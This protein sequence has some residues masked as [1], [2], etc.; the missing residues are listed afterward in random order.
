[1]AAE[2][3]RHPYLLSVEDVAKTLGTDLDRGLSSAQ[4]AE[5][6]Q[7]YPQNILDVG[8]AIPW[9]KI[10]IKQLLNAMIL[11]STLWL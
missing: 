3:E 10:F 2:F 4:V 6:Q 5:L 1:M 11:V 8:G 7:T 9:Y